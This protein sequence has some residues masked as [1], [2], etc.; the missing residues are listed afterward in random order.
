LVI[1]DPI[2]NGFITQLSGAKTE[3]ERVDN[4]LEKNGYDKKTLINKSA[5]EIVEAL[6][7]NEYKIIHLAGHGLYNPVTPGK[8]RNG[9]RQRNISYAI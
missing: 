5:A 2:L 9:N 3:G 8:I 6:F 4:L 7:C 1:A